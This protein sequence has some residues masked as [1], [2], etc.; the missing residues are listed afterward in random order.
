[1][2][3]RDP[4]SGRVRP[5]GGDGASRAVDL[6]G[7]RAVLVALGVGVVFAGGLDGGAFALSVVRA[8]AVLVAHAGALAGA[9]AAGTGL[10][11]VWL[12]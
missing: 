7:I 5:G 6:V 10:P 12:S 11:V 1:M 9:G 2:W 8:G 3:R 4:G